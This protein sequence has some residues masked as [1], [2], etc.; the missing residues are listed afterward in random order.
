M[1]E[2][3]AGLAF[4]ALTSI[5]LAGA[6]Q[7]ACV[8]TGTYWNCGDRM[9]YPKSYPWGTALVD[10]KYSRPMSPPEADVDYPALPPRP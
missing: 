5:G 4:A 2:A 9:I 10:G 3:V 8:W 6:A 7:A 1:K